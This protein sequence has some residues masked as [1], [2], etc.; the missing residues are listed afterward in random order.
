MQLSNINL[1]LYLISYLQ[2][3]P[4]NMGD[5]NIPSSI[6]Y[7]KKMRSLLMNKYKVETILNKEVDSPFLTSTQITIRDKKDYT[8]S[9]LSETTHFYVADVY[10]RDKILGESRIPYKIEDAARSEQY[11]MGVNKIDDYGLPS[12]VS[13]PDAKSIVDFLFNKDLEN[14][15]KLRFTLKLSKRV[16]WKDKALLELRTEKRL[17]EW[18]FYFRTVYECEDGNIEQLK[19]G[20]LGYLEEIERIKKNFNL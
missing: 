8:D 6:D 17:K 7:T 11:F 12:S 16:H 15:E 18:Q 14:S 19:P 5:I 4:L 20:D 10:E 9:N 3:N 1:E 2:T 13:F